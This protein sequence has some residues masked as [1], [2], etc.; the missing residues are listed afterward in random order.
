[1]VQIFEIKW[2]RW[3]N[4]KWVNKIKWQRTENFPWDDVILLSLLFGSKEVEVILK[5]GP[6]RGI[7]T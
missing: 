2:G 4:K 5:K 1:M 3:L 7:E 6:K